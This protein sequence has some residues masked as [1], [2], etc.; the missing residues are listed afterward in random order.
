MGALQ[1]KAAAVTVATSSPRLPTAPLPLVRATVSAPTAAPSPPQQPTDL[2]T[3]ARNAESLQ[4]RIDKVISENQAIVETLDPLWPRRYMRQNSKE[5]APAGTASA[6]GG[7][8]AAIN[9]AALE[10]KSKRKPATVVVNSTASVVAVP[11]GTPPAV[12]PAAAVH[13]VQQKAPASAAVPLSVP[14]N[15][16]HQLPPSQATNNAVQTVAVIKSDVLQVASAG[17][18]QQPVHSLAEP[19][20]LEL[21]VRS[22]NKTAPAVISAEVKNNSSRPG[23]FMLVRQNAVLEGSPTH[24]APQA[25][26]PQAVSAAVAAAA[27]ASAAAAGAAPINLSEVRK[28]PA[29]VVSKPADGSPQSVKEVLINSIAKS[30]QHPANAAAASTKQQQ[31]NNIAQLEDIASTL[32]AAGPPFHPHN[33]EGSMIK[34]LLL[35]TQLKGL[36]PVTVAVTGGTA[37][38]STTSPKRTAEV[39]LAATAN[40]AAAG[41]NV[42]IH[43]SASPSASKPTHIIYA[44]P[45]AGSVTLAAVPLVNKAAPAEARP[46]PAL[47]QQVER[48]LVRCTLCNATFFAS[49][50][51]YHRKHQCHQQQQQQQQQRQSVQS[52]PSK[53]PRLEESATPAASRIYNGGGIVASVTNAAT[54]AASANSAQ[55]VAGGLLQIALTGLHA[56]GGVVSLVKQPQTTAPPV[57]VDAIKSI[58]PTTAFAI[59]GVP[60]PSL[61]GVLTGI[62]S[63]PL[64]ALAGKRAAETTKTTTSNSLL[65]TAA[66]AARPP[67]VPGMPGP[68]S[69]S[70]ETPPAG[71]VSV[72]SPPPSASPSKQQGEPKAPNSSP[73]PVNLC[74]IPE[75]TVSP[76]PPP[77]SSAS[78]IKVEVSASSASDSS[79]SA[80]GAFLRPS[81]LSLTPGS[82]KQKKHVM[83]ATTSGASLVSPDTPR[84]RKSCGLSYQNGTAYTTLGLKCSTRSYYCCIFRPQPVYVEN[85][86]R[87]SMYSN[88]K[89]VAK[90]SHPSG[91]SP[92]ESLNSY[93][94]GYKEVPRNSGLVAMAAT[95]NVKKPGGDMIVAHSSQWKE[96][97]AKRAREEEEERE[98]KKAEKEQT[99]AAQILRASPTK[100]SMASTT[101]ANTTSGPDVSR[102]DDEVRGRNALQR[103]AKANIIS[104]FQFVPS[105][106]ASTSGQQQQQPARQIEGGYKTN[107]DD[108]YTYVR[109]RGRGRYV[110][111][112]CGIRCKKPSM[113]KKHIRTHSNFRPYTCRHCNFSFKTKG[114]LTKHMKSK[115]HHKKCVELG[116]SPVPTS[117]EDELAHGADGDDDKPGTSKSEDAVPGDSDSDIDDDDND[118]DDDEDYE[119]FED[120]EEDVAMAAA[121]A[122]TSTPPPSTSAGAEEATA[123]TSKTS[124]ELEKDAEGLMSLTAGNSATTDENRLGLIGCRPKPSVYPYVSSASESAAR[125]PAAAVPAVG[126]GQLYEYAKI[127]SNNSG[128]ASGSKTNKE[129]ATPAVVTT[130]VAAPNPEKP[131]TL[132]QSMDS[133]IKQMVLKSETASPGPSSSSS[134]TSSSDPKPAPPAIM[135]D[136]SFAPRNVTMNVKDL[137]SKI[138]SGVTPLPLSAAQQQQQPKPAVAEQQLNTM[139]Q[140]KAAS[141]AAAANSA[142][143]GGGSGNAGSAA[144]AATAAASERAAASTSSAGAESPTAVG[145]PVSEVKTTTKATLGSN[146]VN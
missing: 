65:M 50:L 18:P 143:S 90:D 62:K 88:W 96:E 39:L 20:P 67:F 144:A 3:T 126:L 15:L 103:A 31:Q 125:P 132:V 72:I 84:P 69:Q 24:A 104:M 111:K 124:S 83:L 2:S 12:R 33:P 101:S 46:Q 30:S 91:L 87:L 136:D 7:G 134:A 74:K 130:A 13:V 68:Y 1:Q 128:G 42:E 146:Q 70:P 38:L 110:C 107:D 19:R 108:E 29:S 54:A 102:D 105:S 14:F 36:M 41:A 117:A 47:Q 8:P 138:T 77:S 17:L 123:T 9:A 5:G 145:L 35:K 26:R 131:S 75:I 114:N 94:S 4:Q 71:A 73:G 133:V 66:A 106:A 92:K 97:E 122:G 60:T 89:M 49:D 61:S 64:F 76:A 21:T 56:G 6:A 58:V 80:D 23:S 86:H 109:G 37:A 140:I 55:R 45:S 51:D 93:N 95:S 120:A 141:I 40:A 53:R 82:F 121:D 48:K 116:I 100:S 59:P 142:S 112:S 28:L 11:T 16:R 78:E 113:L 85:K 52:S 139:A 115:A 127:S 27:A 137:P 22:P 10:D 129:S 43:K 57:V 99:A 98:K 32:E 34:E 79:S 81:S 119:Q 135:E 63:T 118:D 44:D 25:P